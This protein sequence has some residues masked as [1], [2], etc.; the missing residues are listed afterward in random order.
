MSH[1]SGRPTI[2]TG[3]VIHKLE[4]AFAMGCSDREACLFADIASATLY[5]FQSA[6]PDFI[7]RKALL[8]ENPILLARQEVIKG[9]KDNPDHSLRFL[10]RRKKDEFSL[11]HEL[12][13]SEGG[14]IVTIDAGKNPYN[15]E[16]KKFLPDT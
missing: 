14:P 13:G 8:K 3:E 4:E 12:T 10:E 2:M 6:N 16:A 9:F 11:R 5:N 1:L 7:E 15:G